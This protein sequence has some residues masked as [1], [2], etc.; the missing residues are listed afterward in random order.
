MKALVLTGPGQIELKE[1]DKPSLSSG[2]VLVRM[3]AIALNRRDDWI[4]EGRYP[5]IRYGGILGSDGAGIVD[6]AA[7]EKDGYLVGKDVVINPNIEWGSDP[8]VQSK[9]YTILGMPV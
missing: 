3:K 6:S 7:D 1:V 9:N 2:K 4:R 8:D 5:N